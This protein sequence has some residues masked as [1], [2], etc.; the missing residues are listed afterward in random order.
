MA[1]PP[2][3]N[4]VG[5]GGMR[6]ATAS[7]NPTFRMNRRRQEPEITIG[8]PSAYGCTNN[9]RSVL[10]CVPSEW[11]QSIGLI[12]LPGGSYVSSWMTLNSWLFVRGV[13]SQN[14]SVVHIAG[15]LSK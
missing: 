15:K 9:S 13:A 11:H 2:S 1:W 10:G 14:H 4:A 12:A 7:P 3:S 6:P 8:G 5:W